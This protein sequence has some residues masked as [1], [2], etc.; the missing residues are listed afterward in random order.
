VPYFKRLPDWNFL[1]AA[2]YRNRYLIA[3]GKSLS[4]R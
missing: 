1:S 4:G 3:L 2:D